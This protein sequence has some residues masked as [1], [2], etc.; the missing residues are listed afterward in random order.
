M[1]AFSFA[2]LGFEE[3]LNVK[4]LISKLLQGVVSQNFFRSARLCQ[5]Q[6]GKLLTDFTHVIK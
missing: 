2:R 5:I 6:F 1:H 3:P 4:R